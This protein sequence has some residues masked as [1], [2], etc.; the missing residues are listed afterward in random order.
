MDC[1]L[2]QVKIIPGD[3]YAQPKAGTQFVQF[4]VK[5]V[6]HSSE[7]QHY[8][9]LDFKL[10]TSDGKSTTHSYIV[11]TNYD[12]QLSF[13]DLDPGQNVEGNLIF[14]VPINDHGATISWNPV[15]NEFSDNPGQAKWK[16]G[17]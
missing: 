6:N 17:L 7:K 14:E 8:N 9:P 13:G 2:S 10:L 11:P 1:T 5:I 3:D 15:A 16:L 4:H 12:T